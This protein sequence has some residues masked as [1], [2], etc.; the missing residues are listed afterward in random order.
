MR[1]CICFMIGPTKLKISNH[2]SSANRH[3]WK[4]LDVLQDEKLGV[5]NVDQNFKIGKS[6]RML[7]VKKRGTLCFGSSVVQSLE[8]ILGSKITSEESI[9]SKFSNSRV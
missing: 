4:Y 5:E 2:L 3:T 6:S 1:S 9:K 7:E 8:H